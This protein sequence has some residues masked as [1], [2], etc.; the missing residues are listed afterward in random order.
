MTHPRKFLASLTV[1]VALAGCATDGE[2]GASTTISTDA[3]TTTVSGPVRIS[4]TVGTD[5]APDRIEEVPLGAAVEVTL[6]NAAA[7]ENYHLH[8]YDIETGEVDAGSAAT[9]SFTADKAGE[10]EIESH[11]TEQVLVVIRVG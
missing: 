7:T 9:I 2:S 8:G 3:T 1:V 11:V 5:S 4:V 6:V 10:F